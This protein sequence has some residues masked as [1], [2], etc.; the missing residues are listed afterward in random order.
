MQVNP[1]LAED[2][3]PAD[4]FCADEDDAEL[5]MRQAQARMAAL[6]LQAEQVLDGADGIDEEI[7]VDEQ[8]TRPTRPISATRTVRAQGTAQIP[9]RAGPR[10]W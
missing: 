2:Y 1:V 7:R 3:Y 4:E 10:R 9:P 6:R 8:E 5:L